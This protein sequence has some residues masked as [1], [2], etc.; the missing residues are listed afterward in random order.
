MR[1]QPSIPVFLTLA[2]CTVV[3][4]IIL[5]Q[6][7]G[8]SG[9]VEAAQARQD[10]IKTAEIEFTVKEVVAAGGISYSSPTPPKGGEVP[11][12]ETTLEST[13]RLVISG[14]SI[15][16]ENNHPI[17]DTQ[18][19]ALRPIRMI[20]VCNGQYDKTLFA[21]G[22]N[23][24][25]TPEGLVNRNPQSDAIKSYILAP[26][27]IAL[28][29]LD[30]SITPYLVSQLKPTGGTLSIAGAPCRE[31]TRSAGRD[32]IMTFWFDPAS[33]YAA[34]RIRKEY[35]G[36]PLEQYDITP[37][38]GEDDQWLP[39]SWTRTTYSLEGKVLVATRIEVLRVRL[40]TS[41]SDEQFD[42]SFPP[43]AKV[44]DAR[45]LKD[46]RVKSDGTMREISQATGEELSEVV[47]QPGDS[48][49]NRHRVPVAIVGTLFV[50]MA[51]G[52]VVRVIRRRHA[53]SRLAI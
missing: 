13:N 18:A 3:P 33:G 15:R 42:L 51:L 47:S 52:C 49:L 36:K 14:R 35:Q 37:R 16:Y 31:Y 43:G 53:R 29:G 19:G 2:V 25:N 7:S 27:T 48:W 30:S 34:R 5:A 21:D 44:H 10:A 17:W 12:Q 6:P 1:Y 28:R 39:A 40:N 45:V 20:N 11:A 46:Y 26:M 38:R 4:P 23:A 24:S 32:Q 22:L 41:L 9:L 8:D 50:G